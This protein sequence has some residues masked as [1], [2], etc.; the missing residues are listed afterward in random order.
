MCACECECE[1][2]CVRTQFI[3]IALMS[4]FRAVFGYRKFV[5][6]FCFWSAPISLLLLFSLINF[7]RY[8][9][10]CFCFGASCHRWSGFTSANHTICVRTLLFWWIRVEEEEEEVA[11][12]QI[13]KQATTQWIQLWNVRQYFAADYRIFDRLFVVCA[14]LMAFIIS[15]VWLVFFIFISFG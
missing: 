15:V 4:L 12:K 11:N 9:C 5:A 6:Q 3:S 10:C 14:I 13:I 2:V 8:C 1:C 7:C